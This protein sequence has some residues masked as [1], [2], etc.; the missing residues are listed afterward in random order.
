MG[1]LLYPK[2]IFY[3][4]KRD[5]YKEKTGEGVFPNPRWG[6]LRFRVSGSVFQG[7]VFFRQF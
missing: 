7:V 5:F 4:L 2:A 6:R 3:L 1:I